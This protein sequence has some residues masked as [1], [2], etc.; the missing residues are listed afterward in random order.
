MKRIFLSLLMAALFGGVFLNAA[1]T[2]S[3]SSANAGKSAE[4]IPVITFIQKSDDAS[5]YQVKLNSINE[6]SKYEVSILNADEDIVFT[7]K[8]DAS[9]NTWLFKILHEDLGSDYIL[10]VFNIRN[11]ETGV[12][13]RYESKLKSKTSFEI[14][15]VL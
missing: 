13:Y 9:K 4:T 3:T 14:N 5:F 6:N 8:F 7:Q 1:A 10:P 11:V 2:K 15:T 12:E